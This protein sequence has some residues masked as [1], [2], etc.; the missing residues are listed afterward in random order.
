MTLFTVVKDLVSDLSFIAFHVR[1]FG[2]NDIQFFPNL[3]FFCDKG[4]F[5]ILIYKPVSSVLA[6]FQLRLRGRII[7]YLDRTFVDLMLSAIE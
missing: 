6:Y 1:R 3:V 2:I 4:L 7:W 5:I